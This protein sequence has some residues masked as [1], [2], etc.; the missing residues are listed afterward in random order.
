MSFRDKVSRAELRVLDLLL[1][2]LTNKAIANRLGV[3]ESTVKMHVKSMC[4]RS[5]TMN[6][7][8]LVLA[9]SDGFAMQMAEMRAKNAEQVEHNEKLRQLVLSLSSEVKVLER[10]L[11]RMNPDAAQLA[12]GLRRAAA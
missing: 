11:V 5:G 8:G 4:L 2:G 3:S 12:N 10:L 9:A 1:E 6:R 7:T